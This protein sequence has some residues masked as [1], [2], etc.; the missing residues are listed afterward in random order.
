MTK[1]PKCNSSD[2]VRKILYGLTMEPVDEDV[3][4]TGGCVIGNENPTHTCLKC[5]FNWNQ[6]S[7]KLI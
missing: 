7:E 5:E 3:Y 6:I 4:S 2:G 1:C